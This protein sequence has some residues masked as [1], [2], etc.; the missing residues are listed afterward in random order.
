M[1]LRAR[2]VDA[3]LVEQQRVLGC[4]GERVEFERQLPRVGVRGPLA[5][6][7][8]GGDGAFQVALPMAVRR[9]DGVADPPGARVELRGDGREEAAA[10]EHAAARV[11]EPAVA[12]PPEPL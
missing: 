2:G 4:A 5:Q 1:A 8:S 12:E 3:A 9:S 10:R 6:V 11:V 7:A